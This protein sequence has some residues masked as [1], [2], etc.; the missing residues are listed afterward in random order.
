VT[1]AVGTASEPVTVA[2]V[3]PGIFMVGTEGAI[4]NQDGTLNGPSNPAQRGQ[5]ISIYC[6]GLGATV[7]KGGF[8][9][10]TAATSVVLNGTAVAPSFAGLVPGFVGL[11]QINVTV[12]PSLAPGLTGT[13]AIKEGSQTSNIAP[14]ALE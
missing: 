13:L 4:L 5:Y 3:S 11:Y 14:F 10:V 6:A 9:T 1:G 2:A 12:P 7:A 8:Q